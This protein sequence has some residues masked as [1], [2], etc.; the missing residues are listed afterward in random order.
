[1]AISL[2]ALA[3]VPPLNGF[4]SK[5]LLFMSVLNSPY[6]WLAVAGVINS[7]VS[8]GYYGWIIKRMYM[9]EPDDYSIVK[10]PTSM[11]M[12]FGVLVALIILIGIFPG[13]FISFLQ[14]VVSNI[15]GH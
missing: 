14:S 13:Y 4:W 3:G 10:E 11:V 9:D 15:A 8:M 2:L 5:L 12:I 1:M 7:A 6:S